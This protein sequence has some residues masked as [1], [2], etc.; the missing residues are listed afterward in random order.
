MKRRDMNIANS[1]HGTGM[2]LRTRK[3]NEQKKFSR[4][5]KHKNKEW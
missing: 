5:M 4:K 2:N 1:I 3:H